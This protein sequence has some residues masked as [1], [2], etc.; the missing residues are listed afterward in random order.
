MDIYLINNN[1]CEWVRNMNTSESNGHSHKISNPDSGYTDLENGHKHKLSTGC[2][3]LRKAF[4]HG[5]MM[6]GFTNGHTHFFPS[7]IFNGD[8]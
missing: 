3:K 6:T 1:E 4:F 7:E 2:D 5:K 8:K